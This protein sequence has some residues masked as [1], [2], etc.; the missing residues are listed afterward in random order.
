M[1]TTIIV[2]NLKCGGCAHTI[3]SKIS[4][5]EGIS[6]L[7]VD[8]ASAK[9]SFVHEDINDALVVKDRLKALGYPSIE[10]DNSMAAKAISFFSCATGK[11]S[12]S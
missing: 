7:R 3:T 12:K 5:M 11:M 9:V 1:K 2:Q 8:V 10:S 6:D 4:G